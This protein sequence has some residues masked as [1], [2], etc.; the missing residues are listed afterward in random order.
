MNKELEEKL[1][2][3]IMCDECNGVGGYLGSSMGYCECNKCGGDGHR[4][5]D[6]EG[7]KLNDILE[8]LTS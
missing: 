5:H 1:K 4:I 8:D 6:M 3:L 7:I 2:K